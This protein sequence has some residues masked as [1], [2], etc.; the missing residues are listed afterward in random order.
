M[1][2]KF[3]QETNMND[4]ARYFFFLFERNKTKRFKKQLLILSAF[5]PFVINLLKEY[6]ITL[7]S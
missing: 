3:D 4:S 6:L 5:K 1:S 7:S 2:G